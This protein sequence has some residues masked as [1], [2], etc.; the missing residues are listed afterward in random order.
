MVPVGGAYGRSSFQQP[1]CLKSH[2]VTFMLGA[3]TS[4]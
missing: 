1:A 3:F 4:F 2:H